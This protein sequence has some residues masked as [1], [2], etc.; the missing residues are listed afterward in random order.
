VTRPARLRPP[1]RIR[2]GAAGN[3]DSGARLSCAVL[4]TGP[5]EWAAVDLESGAFVRARPSMLARVA[6]TPW[7]LFDV[8]LV[9]IGIEDEPPDPARS[10]GVPLAE[11]PQ[12]V[13]RMRRRG[14]R[15]LLSRLAVP[16]QRWRA[17]LGTHG[18]SV[19]YVDLDVSAP[20]IALV[21]VA[22][23][24][25]RCFIRDDGLPYCSFTWGGTEQALPLLDARV[26]APLRTSGLGLDGQLLAAA[27]GGKPGYLVVGLGAVRAGHAPKVVLSV[28]ARRP[29][30]DGRANAITPPVS[31][32]AV[33]PD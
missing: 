1:R 21:T 17:L 8:A 24:S 18:P 28:V 19:A 5:E 25:L 12:P 27:V 31:P 16:E 14:A 32:E 20:S 9:T 22:A 15:R 2:A 11:V 26:V 3:R 13:G 10:E 4:A 30:P 33:T 23:K 29:R 6:E 7:S